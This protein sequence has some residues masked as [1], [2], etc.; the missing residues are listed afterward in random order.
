MRGATWFV[1]GA[2]FVVGFLTVLSF[3]TGT[4]LSNAGDAEAIPCGSAV[5][6]SSSRP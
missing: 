5:P 3:A 2:L 1:G 6:I 4:R